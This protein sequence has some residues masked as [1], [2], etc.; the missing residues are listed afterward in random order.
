MR[1]NAKKGGPAGRIER[2]A[3]GLPE[4]MEPIPFC[5]GIGPL[6]P[7]NIILENILAF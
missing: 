5:P 3:Q 7:P 4:K 1:V 2:E 6:L